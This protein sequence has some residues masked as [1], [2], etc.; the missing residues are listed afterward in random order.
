MING[1]VVS[2]P[3]RYVI[4][5]KGLANPI[6]SLPDGP[7]I[8]RGRVLMATG[9]SATAA[10]RPYRFASRVTF[11][12]AMRLRNISTPSSYADC[13]STQANAY[14]QTDPFFTPEPVRPVPER[15]AA[16]HQH[17]AGPGA[18]QER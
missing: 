18:Y 3:Y 2:R 12:I 17:A 9:W 8:Q 11:S 15:Q 13:L 5:W 14:C 16:P 1:L 10:A 7:I 4:G 6:Y